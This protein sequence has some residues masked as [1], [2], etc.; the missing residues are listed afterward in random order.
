MLI[1]TILKFIVIRVEKLI[2]YLWELV[3]TSKYF[4]YFEFVW[5]RVKWMRDWKTLE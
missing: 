2:E 1:E 4:K 5:S 3:N